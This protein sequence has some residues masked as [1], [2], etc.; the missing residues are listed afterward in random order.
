MPAGLSQITQSNLSAQ[1]AHDAGHAL[2]RER[3][4]VAGLRGRQQAQRLDPLVADQRLRQLGVALGDVDEVVHH[5]ALGAHDE[6]E[7]AQ[8]DVEI[9]DH[10]LLAALRQRGA[11]RGG[12]GGLADAALARC[13]DQIL[14]PLSSLLF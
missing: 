2:A 13:D 8:A 12:G 14:W 5:P 9:D 1:L 11:E 7:V 10:D 3:V 4:L 6:I